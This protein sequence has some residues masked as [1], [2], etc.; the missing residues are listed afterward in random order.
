MLAK[1]HHLGRW[2]LVSSSIWGAGAWQAAP[3]GALVLGKQH[4][5]GYWHLASRQRHLGRAP[6][7]APS[8]ALICG[9]AFV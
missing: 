5:L 9:I 1:Q 8:G 6:S 2:R 7:G 3:S 4:H